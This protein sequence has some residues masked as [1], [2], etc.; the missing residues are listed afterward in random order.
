MKKLIFILSFLAITGLSFGQS[1]GTV[2]TFAAGNHTTTATKVLDSLTTVTDTAYFVIPASDWEDG[3][4]QIRSIR[5]SGTP[6]IT[7][8]LQVSNN[9]ADWWQK[10]VA[11][12]INLKPVA[13]GKKNAGFPITDS[14][15]MYYRV[16]LVN[17]TADDAVFGSVYFRTK[18]K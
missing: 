1:N 6:V 3:S 14:Q 4:I 9:N 17:H 18:R 8:Y 10:S 13:N 12:T 7:G 5:I 2:Y 11:D 16:M 15:Y